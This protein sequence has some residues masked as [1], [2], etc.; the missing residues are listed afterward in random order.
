MSTKER[1]LV[2][3]RAMPEKSSKHGH[4]VCVAGI[5][6]KGE[7]RR[8]YPFKFQYGKGLTDFGKRDVLEAEL[9]P[10][11]NDKIKESR[12]VISYKVAGQAD[13]R[14]SLKQISPLVTS[15]EKLKVGDASL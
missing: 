3:T 8:L 12:K 9:T 4:L 2:L 5:T 15:L 14:S 1:I 10:P 7:W 11:D 6:E 13:Y